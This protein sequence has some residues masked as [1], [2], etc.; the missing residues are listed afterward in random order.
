MLSL[1]WQVILGGW[2]KNS[3]DMIPADRPELREYAASG[4][5]HFA[6]G[7]VP[8]NWL[9]PQCSAAVIHGGAGTVAAVLQAGIPCIVTPVMANDQVCDDD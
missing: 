2:A 9:L 4:A 8:H 5:V 6:A 3:S 1:I 7:K